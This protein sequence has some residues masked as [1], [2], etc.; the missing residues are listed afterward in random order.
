MDD[1]DIRTTLSDRPHHMHGHNTI[2][3]TR[4]ATATLSYYFVDKVYKFKNVE[5][6]VFTFKQDDCIIWFK[7]FTYIRKTLD[8]E[9]IP[10][11]KYYAN[12]RPIRA[13]NEKQCIGGLVTALDGNPATLGYYEEVESDIIGKNDDGVKYILDPH[14]SVT[15]VA[16]FD[17]VTLVLQSKET[18]EFTPTCD[19]ELVEYEVAIRLDTDEFANLLYNDSIIIEPQAPI[20]IVDS[21]YSNIKDKKRGRRCEH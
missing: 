20:A 6:M 13:D 2:Y 11:K 5:Q 19:E 7:M 4:G 9:V 1:F 16:G 18:A 14:F 12:V 17:Y 15:S 10:G 21:L 8:T 3:I